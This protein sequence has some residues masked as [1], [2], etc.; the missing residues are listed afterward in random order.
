M[1][2]L[3][4]LIMLASLSRTEL[5]LVFECKT[6]FPDEFFASDRWISLGSLLLFWCNQVKEELI[7]W[8]IK[9]F[10]EAVRKL[11]FQELF[12]NYLHKE[13]YHFKT[14]YRI[15]GHVQDLTWKA[16]EYV[17]LDLEKRS[18]ICLWLQF[19]GQTQILKLYL[20]HFNTQ[21]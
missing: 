19:H 21:W 13:Q 2:S 11:F 18:D 10:Y 1:G 5:E 3:F 20:K 17:L 6:Y 16:F 8:K 15:K 7:I 12:L 14:R 9:Y 4:T